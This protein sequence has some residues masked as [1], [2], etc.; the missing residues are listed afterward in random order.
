MG[1]AVPPYGALTLVLVVLMGCTRD[2]AVAPMITDQDPTPV[3]LQLPAGVLAQL[4]APT[5]PRTT[6]SLP[7]ASPWG[8]SSSTKRP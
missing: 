8:G 2:V 3:E 4:G 7:K 1:G 5:F 6:R